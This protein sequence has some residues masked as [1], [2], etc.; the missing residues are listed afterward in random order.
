MRSSGDK[1]LVLSE[2]Q[3]RMLHKAV[4]CNT[5]NA[6]YLIVLESLVLYSDFITM[7]EEIFDL[8]TFTV[9]QYMTPH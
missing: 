3:L 4:A 6:I 8:P 2:H 1:E 9:G 7:S 5:V